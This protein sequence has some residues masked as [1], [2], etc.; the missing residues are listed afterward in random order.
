MGMYY[1]KG[2]AL[3]KLAI[4]RY[5]GAGKEKLGVYMSAGA[6][7]LSLPLTLAELKGARRL[8]DLDQRLYSFAHEIFWERVAC[9]EASE[10]VK[11]AC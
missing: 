9:A 7:Q 2:Y 5:A 8:V 1:H 3:V 6:K 4:H 11:M 10:G